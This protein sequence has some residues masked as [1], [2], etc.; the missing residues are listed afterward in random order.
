MSQTTFLCPKCNQTHP[1]LVQDLGRKLFCKNSQAYFR[2]S[3]LDAYVLLDVLGNG[4]FGIVYR[5]Y[6]LQ[7][8]REV[9]LKQ[10]NEKAVP[11][12]EFDS[13]VQRAVT[14]ARAL[15]K[16]EIHPNV[17]PLLTSGHVGRQFFMVTP[18]VRGQTLEKLIPKGGFSDPCQAV[19]TAIVIL[20]A[21]EHVHGFKVY[22]RDV[23]PSNI[24]IDGHGNLFLVDFGL[25]ACR[26]IDTAHH[27]EMGTVLGTPAFMPPEQA[28]GEIDRIGPWSDQYGAGAVL[29]KMLTGAVPYPGKGY[30]VLGDVG[31]YD[32]PPRTL[33]H[34][35]PRLDPALE[36]L[37]MQS[38][39]KFPGDRFPNCEKFA[40]LLHAWSAKQ[41]GAPVEHGLADW[42]S[43]APPSPPRPAPASGDPVRIRWGLW[44]AILLGI[45]AAAGSGWVVWNCMTTT[46]QAPPIQFFDPTKKPSNP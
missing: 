23:K 11:E 2:L 37:V 31:N 39:A 38:L 14:E 22:H 18:I 5:A 42:P 45:A 34:F 20:R 43:E 6:D 40:Q 16:I 17:L 33:R 7:N 36:A 26:Q 32:K 13:W 12:H 41:S 8:R 46:K 9:A 4:A 15:A 19:Q 29:F 1:V 24:M 3:Q 28:R 27:T 44:A 21:L 10:L 30:A 35:R 25:A